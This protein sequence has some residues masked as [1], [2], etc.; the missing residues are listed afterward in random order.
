MTEIENDTHPGPGTSAT[1]PAARTKSDTKSATPSEHTTSLII[2]V[3]L[4]L[5]NLRRLDVAG[6]I[7]IQRYHEPRELRTDTQPGIWISNYVG[8]CVC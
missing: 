2:A 7:L 8:G 6:Y 4:H 1:S 5:K 3:P